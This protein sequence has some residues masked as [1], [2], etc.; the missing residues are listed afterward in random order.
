MPTD[1]SGG[2]ELRFIDIS[3]RRAGEPERDAVRQALSGDAH[4]CLGFDVEVRLDAGRVGEADGARASRGSGCP[5][6]SRRRDRSARC[7]RAAAGRRCP[8]AAGR[9]SRP[10]ARGCSRPAATRARR[11]GCRNGRA[12]SSPPRPPCEGRAAGRQV[13]EIGV[14]LEALRVEGVVHR[15]G[16]SQQRR[17]R[18]PTSDRSASIVDTKP[19]G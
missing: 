12:A 8:A 3:R 7:R 16:P 14:R 13:E 2:S 15:D 4:A 10:C 17:R 5:R 6:R 9:R 19:S 1:E 18:L 11:S